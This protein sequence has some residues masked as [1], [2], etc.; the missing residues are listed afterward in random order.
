MRYT[1]SLRNRLGDK[2]VGGGN[3]QTQIALGFMLINQILGLFR[4]HGAYY[5]VHV[6]SM[7]GV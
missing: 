4:H 1:V 7:Q 6:L 5:R 3:H 2:A